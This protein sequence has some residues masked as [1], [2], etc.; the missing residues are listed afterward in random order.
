MLAAITAISTVGL[1]LNG[2]SS[3]DG[4]SSKGEQRLITSDNADKLSS[5]DFPM[6][7]DIGGKVTYLGCDVDPKHHVHAGG[8][9]TVTHYWKVK[10]SPGP[11]W[12]LCGYLGPALVSTDQPLVGDKHAVADWKAGDS[13]RDV[14]VVQVPANWTAPVIVVYVGLCQGT[15]RMGVRTGEQDGRDSVIA[16]RMPVEKQ[17]DAPTMDVRQ[18]WR[19]PVIDGKLDDPAWAEIA[20]TRFMVNDETGGSIAP[21]TEFKIMWD[22]DFLYVGF[23]GPDAPRSAGDGVTVILAHDGAK[24]AITIDVSSLGDIQISTPSLIAS[25]AQAAYADNVAAGLTALIAWG[26]K[27]RSLAKINSAPTPERRVEAGVADLGYP[28]RDDSYSFPSAVAQWSAEV[29]VPWS[30]IPNT[31]NK[32]SEGIFRLRGNLARRHQF[33]NR[34]KSLSA[35]SPSFGGPPA[36]FTHLGVL[37]LVD[38]VGNPLVGRILAPPARPLP[39]EK[40]TF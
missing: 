35:W 29:A 3:D 2:C 13:I 19:R 8:S 28:D 14:Q 33:K 7:A 10:D 31:D 37:N 32:S 21:R 36:D 27:N 22:L 15:T 34:D 24:N 1:E 25:T 6:Y 12:T 9:F 16:V 26:G 18:A 20:A 11:D 23:L 40:R 4:P 17:D 5:L 38:D 39:G 30:S